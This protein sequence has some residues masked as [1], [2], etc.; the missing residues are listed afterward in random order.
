MGDLWKKSRIAMLLIW[1][2]KPQ[3]KGFYM[4][5]M[6]GIQFVNDL[7]KIYLGLNTSTYIGANE[8]ESLSLLTSPLRLA[9]PHL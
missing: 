5:P 6:C 8:R 2:I 3:N 1:N 4:K 7:M 9:R